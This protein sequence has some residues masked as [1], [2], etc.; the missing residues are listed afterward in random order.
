MAAPA[1]IAE[2]TEAE[3]GA[4]AS[5]P[6]LFLELASNVAVWVAGG[7]KVVVAGVAVVAE[8]PAALVE[9]VLLGPSLRLR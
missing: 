3:V 7:A 9:V 6:N 5:T 2:L 1:E 8:P 4:G